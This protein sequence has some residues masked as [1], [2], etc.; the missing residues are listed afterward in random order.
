[1][2]NKEEKKKKKIHPKQKGSSQVEIQSSFF[3][4]RKRRREL[5]WGWG[6]RVNFCLVQL[7]FVERSV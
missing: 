5:G 1:M 7:S 3:N 2:T 6:K 4:V